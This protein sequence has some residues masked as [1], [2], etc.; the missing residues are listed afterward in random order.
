MAV[1]IAPASWNVDLLNGRIMVGESEPRLSPL[2][3]CLPVFLGIHAGGASREEIGRALHAHLDDAADAVKV[4][5][6]RVRLKIGD[7]TC[8]RFA[9]GRY[10]LDHDPS[11]EL[12]RLE[13]AALAAS[14]RDRVLEQRLRVELEGY[15]A[16]LRRRRPQVLLDQDWFER[17]ERHLRQLERTLAIRLAADAFERRDFAT[18][19]GLSSDLVA[20]DSLDEEAWEIAIRVQLAMGKRGAALADFLRYGDLL[21]RELGTAPPQRLRELLSI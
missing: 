16:R 6:Y 9:Q 2:E 17:V 3:R 8:I 11:H 1:F 20:L 7:S 13:H 18:A 15:R 19:L 12:R 4:L 10:A 14:S 5:V 21:Q